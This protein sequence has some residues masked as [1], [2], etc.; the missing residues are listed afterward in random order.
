M[1][2]VV[3]IPITHMEI[4]MNE[5]MAAAGSVLANVVDGT[6]NGSKRVVRETKVGSTSFL[7]GYKAQRAKNKARSAGY[8][9]TY[10]EALGV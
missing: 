1:P 9:V 10:S 5:V 6:I 2:G 3:D 7:A 8:E 4:D